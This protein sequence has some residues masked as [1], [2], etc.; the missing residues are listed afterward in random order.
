MKKFL[1]YFYNQIKSIEERVRKNVRLIPDTYRSIQ[2][3]SYSCAVH[4]VYSILHHHNIF[5]P[6]AEIKN[7]LG[8]DKEGTDTEPILEYLSSMKLKVEIN[9]KSNLES[10]RNNINENNLM[11]ITVDEWEHWIVIYG[12]SD[13]RIFVLDSNKLNLLN[14]MN[15]KEFLNRWDNNW[16]AVVKR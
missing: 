4:V 10:I 13:D 14:S 16:T 8:T 5:R 15:I 11:I 1:D 2:T 6:I 3:D 9:E 7:S 12:Y